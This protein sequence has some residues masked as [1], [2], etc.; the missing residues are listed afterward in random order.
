MQNKN[1][2]MKIDQ[3]IH[4]SL[5]FTKPREGVAWQYAGQTEAIIGDTRWLP[6]KLRMWVKIRYCNVLICFTTMAPVR[7]PDGAPP[8]YSKLRNLGEI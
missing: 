6:V 2:V 1:G 5:S 8:S 3:T 4:A 7:C